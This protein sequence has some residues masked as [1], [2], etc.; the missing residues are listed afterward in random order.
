MEPTIRKAF[1]RFLHAAEVISQEAGKKLD[2]NKSRVANTSSVRSRRSR[3]SVKTGSTRSSLHSERRIAMAEAA[4]AK[5]QAEYDRLIAQMEKDRKQCEAQEEEDD[6]YSGKSSRKASVEPLERT[7]AWVENQPPFESDVVRM[8]KRE[9]NDE[10][11]QTLPHPIGH[12]SERHHIYETQEPSRVV[13]QCMGA[14]ATTNEKLTASLA[15]LSLPKCHPDVFSGDATMFHPWKSAFKGMTESCNVTPENEMNYLCMYTTGE[16]RKLVNSYRKRRHK[17]LT[18]AFL[19]RLRESARFGEYDKKKLQAFSDLCSDVVSQ[20]SQLP[21]LACL[22]YPNA[23]R[24]ILYNLPESLRNRWDKQVVEFTQKNKDAY[25]DFTVFASMIEK[26]SLLKN[27]P[28]VTAFEKRGKGDRRKPFIPPLIPPEDPLHTVLAGETKTED[29]EVKEKHCPFHKCIGHTLSECKSFAQKTLEE[30]TQWIKEEKLCFR[31]LVA[32]HIANQCKSKVKC[33]K[34]SSERHPTLLHKEK[35]N[36]DARSKEITSARMSIGCNADR[37]VCCSKTDRRRRVYTIV[38]EQSNTSM[39]SPELADGLG[40]SGPKE[41]YLLSTCSGSKETRFGRR[42][43]GLMV[44]P[45]KG[46]P[47][48]L[49]T[50]IECDNI[51][52]DKSEIPSPEFAMKYTH[53]L[54]IA[55]E[56]PSLDSRAEVQLLIGRNAPELLKVRAF[57]NGPNGTLWAHKLAVG[58]TICGQACVD[59]QGGPIHVGTHRTIYYDP[60]RQT[61]FEQDDVSTLQRDAKPKQ[62]KVTQERSHTMS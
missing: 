30:K 31:C 1:A 17:D 29:E 27:H 10:F 37:N 8:I 62:D 44:T 42:V 56:I 7:K 61:H 49:P 38:D 52:K 39:I 2:N 15:K 48:E 28:N 35:W 14:I 4:A 26:Q 23:I 3:T 21:G 9:V 24:P 34:C 41:K 46:K 50:L 33:G 59:R 22:N 32:G 54:S 19:T 55:D 40:I 58:W 13:Q 5:E 18:N 12:R 11:N 20:V 25:P 43:P 6:S 53:L 47:L 51:P 16:P 36:N 60:P 57:C 45:V